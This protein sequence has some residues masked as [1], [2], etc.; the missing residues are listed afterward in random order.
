MFKGPSELMLHTV[1]YPF[2]RQEWGESIKN[3]VRCWR[4]WGRWRPACSGTTWRLLFPV[5]SRVSEP[6]RRVNLFFILGTLLTAGKHQLSMNIMHKTPMLLQL[7]DWAYAAALLL[8]GHLVYLVISTRRNDP[9]RPY[10]CTSNTQH[11]LSTSWK[12]E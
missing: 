5:M 9:T 12:I 6:R 2:K 11:S 8:L 7:P 1:L 4:W 10:K 3:R